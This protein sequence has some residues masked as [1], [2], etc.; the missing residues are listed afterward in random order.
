M[1]KITKGGLVKKK[2]FR[3]KSKR[4]DTLIYEKTRVG[5][6]DMPKT[7]TIRILK[8]G[9]KNIYQVFRPQKSPLKFLSKKELR[10]F[11]EM[12]YNINV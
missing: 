3:I 6:A 10:D 8:K 2:Y 9:R 12:F 1:V 7:I 11:L 4:K 5:L